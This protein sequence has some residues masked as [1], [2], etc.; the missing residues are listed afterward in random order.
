MINLGRLGFEETP[1]SDVD[2]PLETGSSGALAASASEGNAALV[3]FPGAA[4]NFS[5]F[6]DF[7]SACK[8]N[9][10]YMC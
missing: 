7:S 4:A 6:S 3:M 1:E 2:F 10:W 8:R 9:N 5:D